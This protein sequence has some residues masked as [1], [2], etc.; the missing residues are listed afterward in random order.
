MNKKK[1]WLWLLA[2]S[3]AG[4]GILL[5]AD[6]GHKQGSQQTAQE[7][8][9]GK[10]MTVWGE[11]L[12]MACY[13]AHEGKGPKHKKCAKACIL[14]GAPMGLLTS[15]GRVMLLV[16]DHDKKN[17][18]ESL[19]EWAADKVKVSGNLYQRGGLRALVVLKAEKSK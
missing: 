16:E 12:D 6:E 1:V 5:M 2:A 15:D 8:V 10:A 4:S 3:L 14:G 11:V 18:Y 7:S 13:M 17:I 19:K 9:E